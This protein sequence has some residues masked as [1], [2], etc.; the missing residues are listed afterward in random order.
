MK[1]AQV[2]KKQK[3]PSGGTDAQDIT[4]SIHTKH[5]ACMFD[6]DVQI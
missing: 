3:V 4:G 6:V 5:L 2:Q 1:Y